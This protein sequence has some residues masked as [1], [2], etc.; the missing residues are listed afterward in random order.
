MIQRKL[1]IAV[2]GAGMGGLAV[3]AT[4][5]QIGFE[6]QVYEQAHQFTRIGAGI[7]M[8]PNS[9][10]VLRG[11][12][13]EERLRRTAFQPYS[14]LNREGYSGQ[15]MRELPMP[16]SLFGAPYLCMHRA[17]LHALLSAVPKDIVHLNKKLTGIDQQSSKVVLAFADGTSVRSDAVIGADGIHSVVRDI[18][19]GPDTRSIRD[20]SH[21]VPYS[22]PHCWTAWMPDRLERNGGVPIGTSSFT[23]RMPSDQK[24]TSSRA[25]QNPPSGSRGNRG[26]QR[27]TRRNCA[28]RM[29]ISTRM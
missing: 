20:G 13:V 24:F 15:V 14:H 26:R 28:R 7:Q 6:V 27:V 19:V 21:I 4:L 10:K 11:I 5:R 2:V 17:D 16:D 9:M 1:S 8:M 18:I 3:A 23:I 25:F 29:K 22:L 12:G